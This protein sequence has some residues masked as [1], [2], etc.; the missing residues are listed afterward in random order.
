MTWRPKSLRSK[1]GILA[2]IVVVL[3]LFLFRPGLYRVRYRIAASIGNALGRRVTIDNVRLRVLPRPG[4]DLEGL[5]IYDAPEFSAEPMIRAQEV[6]AP[7]R[8]RSLFRGRIEIATLSATEPS[9]NLVRNDQGRWN[10]ATLLERNA[11]IPAAPTQK[12]AFERRPAFPYLEASSARINFKIGQTKKS[13]ALINADV[14]LWQDSENSWGARING[15]PVRT[16]F[17]LTDTGTLLIE[18]KWERASSLSLTPLQLSLQWQKGQLGQLTKLFTGKDRGWR[19]DVSLRTRLA[20]TPS[21]LSIVTQGSIDGFHRYDIPGS[22][23]V[24]LAATCSGRYNSGTTALSELQCLSPVNSGNVSLRGSAALV[25]EVP[26]YDL[27]IAADKV[28]LASVVRLLRQAKKQIPLQLTASGLLDANFHGTRSIASSSSPNSQQLVTQ[29]WNGTGAATDVR[30]WS[31]PSAPA[32]NTAISAAVNSQSGAKANAGEIDVAN[33]PLTLIGI[34]ADRGHVRTQVHNRMQNDHDADE[35]TLRIGPATLAMSASP[36]LSVGGWVSKSGYHFFLRGDTEIKNLFRIEKAITLSAPHSPAQGQVKFDAGVSGRWQGFPIPLVAGTAQLRNVRAEIRGLNTPIEIA[37]A[38]LSLGPDAWLV[39]KISAHT[40]LAGAGTRWSGGITVPI[41]CAHSIDTSANNAN[42]DSGATPCTYQFD[43]LADRL[44]AGDLAEW[45]TPASVDRPWYQILKTDSNASNRANASPLLALRAR[46]NLRVSHLL[47][48]NVMAEQVS[49]Q[50]DADRGQIKLNGLRAHLLQGTHRGNW[51]IDANR[52]VASKGEEAKRDQTT[53]TKAAGSVRFQ[54]AGTLQDV[55]LDQVSVL[56]NSE[57]I[58]GTA[59]GTFSVEG[60]GFRD[61]PSHCNGHVQFVMRNGALTRIELPGSTGALTVRSFSGSLDL[62]EGEWRLLAG[63]LQSDD[64]DFGVS[65][66]AFA[67]GK[68]DFSLKNDTT[69][70]PAQTSIQT[71]IQTWTI[72]GN[73]AEPHVA[74][75]NQPGQVNI[76]RAEIIAKP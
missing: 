22:E 27:S 65:G 43:L 54:G 42:P 15:A 46:G 56:M 63:R 14:A 70:A 53:N 33:I 18:G 55:S 11:Q 71:S 75:G 50:F 74:A 58:T 25:S 69:Q 61:L 52:S 2:V 6:S 37:S 13:Y 64:A 26:I 31:S 19:G 40:G 76:K 24:R 66:N 34:T 30:I 41:N 36:P 60:S 68:L 29:L 4:F 38:N 73:L 59:D 32:L 28:P 9:I 72:T 23:N 39:Q 49:T 1:R 47:L 35:T 45:F 17:N 12:R 10:L 5:V 7:I 21:A 51:I 3:L 16:D 57:W 48:N 20:G 8:F 62:K 67:D 44:S